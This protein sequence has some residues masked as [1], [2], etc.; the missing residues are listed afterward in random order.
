MKPQPKTKNMTY[1]ILIKNGIIIDGTGAPWIKADIATEK[2]RIV[3]IGKI[4]EGAEKTIDAKGLVVS[5]GWIDIHVHA[6]HNILGNPEGMSYT[7]QGVTTV[8]M[9]NCGL[10]TYPLSKEHRLDLIEYLKPFT[11]GLQMSYEWSNLAEFNQL[12]MKTGT[13][14]NLVPFVGHGSLRIAAMG[15]DNR[16]PEES[17]MET[18]KQLL[19]EAMMQ[20]S[21]GMSTGLGYPPGFYTKDSELVELSKILREYGGM[22][23]THMR[24]EDNNLANTIKLGFEMGVPVQISHLGSS[25]GSRKI[26]RGR[27][28]ETT[29]RQLDEA[30][31]LGLDISA[32]IYPYTAGSS[33]LSQV[34]PDWL[35]AGGVPRM[36]EKLS[37]PL[38]RERIARDYDEMGRDFSKIIVSYVKSADNK[39]IE[40][41]NIQDISEKWGQSIVDTVCELMIDERG[42]AMNITFW[43]VEEDVDTMVK[44]PAV[45]PCSDGWL[46]APTGPLGAGKPHPR[47][48]GAFPRY[49]NQYVTEKKI[50]RLEDAVRRM[51]SLPASRLGLQDR[52]VL[53]E[54]LKA[55]ITVFNPD[56]IRD[57]ST[58]EQPHQYPE[59]INH[60]VINGALT[61]EAGEHT[62]VLNGE[63]IRK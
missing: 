12:I 27:H 51:T 46:L 14:L 62:G 48:Y 53:R 59:G 43:G 33:L 49:L 13:S 34:I 57:R 60:V 3:R 36:L 37:D 30:R 40:G 42:E 4:K 2:D 58:F 9:G 41:M 6:D 7:H 10:S 26:L 50:L 56:T 45:M 54:G 25:C 28:E 19:T 16:A 39:N 15:F 17:E 1:D 29:L 31:R 44:H 32:D 61:I 11:S 63:I 5:P 55:D 21:H 20:G 38:I 23:S 8:T 47:C 35:H 52:G 24:G 18:M 22:Y